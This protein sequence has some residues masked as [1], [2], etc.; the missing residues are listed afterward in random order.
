MNE[1]EPTYVVIW[2]VCVTMT[3]CVRTIV[4]KGPMVLVVG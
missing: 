1:E 2:L 3:V 4:F